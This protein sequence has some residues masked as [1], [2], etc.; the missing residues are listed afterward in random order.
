MEGDNRGESRK[1]TR[2]DKSYK[3]RGEDRYGRNGRS[4]RHEYR[5]R[6]ERDRDRDR[7]DD[8]R[9]RQEL[10]TLRDIRTAINYQNRLLQ[11][12][13]VALG[14]PE[15]NTQFGYRGGSNINDERSFK[16]DEN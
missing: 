2:E 15:A 1:R 6:D 3:D 11:Q 10:N 16:R 5:G 14:V 13:A 4:D 9:E 12:V 7:R 8:G